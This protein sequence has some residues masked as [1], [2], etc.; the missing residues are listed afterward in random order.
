MTAD[1]K[2]GM[3]K[4]YVLVA[5][6]VFLTGAF[7]QEMKVVSVVYSF[8]NA[9]SDVRSVPLADNG[10]GSWRL[11]IKKGDV[12]KNAV[13]VEVFADFSKAIKGDKG[14]AV[15]PR[16]EL[17]RFDADNGVFNASVCMPV[18]GM[19]SEQGAFAAIAKGYKNELSIRAEISNGCYNVY[20]YF[21]VKATGVPV[22]EDI[23]IDYYFLPE[24]ATYADMARIYRNYQLAR[25][26]VIPMKKRVKKQPKLEYLAKSIEV[27][28]QAHAGKPWPSPVEDQTR[29]NEP[30]VG[31]NERLTYSNSALFLQNLKNAGVEYAD[32][33]SCGWNSGGHDGRYPQIL[34]V[35]TACGSMEDFNSFIETAKSLGYQ[36]APHINYTDA[37]KVA[38]IWS[39]DII[40][41]NPE[42][43][44]TR[45]AV[46]C[47][48]RAYN[49]CAK[50]AWEKFIPAQLEEIAKLGFNGALYIDVLSAINPYQCNAEGHAATHK[51]QAKYYNKILARCKKIWGLAASECGF[52]QVI[53]N[54]DYCN[55]ISSKIRDQYQ[56]KGSPLVAAIVP[57]WQIVY[58]GSVLS[59]PDRITQGRLFPY[60]KLKLV[61]FG[62]RPVFYS[63]GHPADIQSI[64]ESYK[65]YAPLA[66]LQWEFMDDHREVAP[67]VFVTTYSN[68]D[69]T[70]CNYGKAPCEYRGEKVAP[71]SYALI[72]KR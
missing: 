5:F 25:K 56:G 4:L 21:N 20:P 27:R 41:R 34:P 23:K 58:H 44:F 17:M 64:A 11:L 33:C 68:G 39:D 7:A 36:I 24:S 30:K 42:G 57:F 31:V 47:G 48:G 40:C 10:D 16:N 38:D 66:Y 46:W 2:G 65:T 12:P 28:L 53:K 26:A 72:K 6:A 19:K 32:I 49:L 63:G 18:Y 60:A 3:K 71:M 50:A 15:F 67:D 37:Y 9:P 70:V 54:I 43:K 55:Y 22:Y 69:E 8:D 1:R 51:E 29:E 35:E 52:D 62:G 61:E 14:F 45:N 59:N 13:K